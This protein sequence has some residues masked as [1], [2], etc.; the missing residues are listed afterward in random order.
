MHTADVH[1][2]AGFATPNDAGHDP[3][4]CVCPLVGVVQGLHDNDGDLLIIAGDLFDHR[5]VPDELIQHALAILGEVEVPVVVLPGNH[6]LFHDQSLY[7]RNHEAVEASGIQLVTDP[8]GESFTS[9]DG[10]VNFWGRAMEDHCPQFQPL[11]GMPSRPTDDAW[12][13]ALAHGHFT[14]DGVD[15]PLEHHRSSPI[16]REELA[17]A[18]ADYLAM[19]H[20]HVLTEVTQ[21]STPA[22]YAGSPMSAWSPG[23]VL[24]VDLVEGEEIAVR[25]SEVPHPDG[26]PSAAPA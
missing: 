9:L 4:V 11:G 3:D 15:H 14:G 7:L 10:A 17:D 25:W 24:V 20:W 19:G 2:G 6:D 18:G 21:G 23:G 13:V 16:S 5:A 22:W 1:L 12:Y 8:S 26:C